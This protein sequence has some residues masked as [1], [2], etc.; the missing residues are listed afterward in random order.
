V[1]PVKYELGFYIPEDKIFLVCCRAL[2]VPSR[3]CSANIN[4]FSTIFNVV[5]H[6]NFQCVRELFLVSDHQGYSTI[7]SRRVFFCSK[8]SDLWPI[9][10]FESV[11]LSL[12][13]F[14]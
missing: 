4:Y 3:S 8:G 1:S 2:S 13:Q 9:P 11:F 12:Y 5:D 7:C 6:R 10:R 14:N